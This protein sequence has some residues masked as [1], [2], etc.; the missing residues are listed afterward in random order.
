MNQ[1]LATLLVS[2]DINTAIVAMYTQQQLGDL[3]THSTESFLIMNSENGIDDF[4]LTVKL[5]PGLN[6]SSLFLGQ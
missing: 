1:Q 5:D 4:R 6:I 3:L 2:H